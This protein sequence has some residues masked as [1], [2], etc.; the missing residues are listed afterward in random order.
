[1]E[2]QTFGGSKKKAPGPTRTRS[3]WSEGSLPGRLEPGLT[4]LRGRYRGDL[5]PVSLGNPENLVLRSGGFVSR[6]CGVDTSATLR[7]WSH[8]R[9]DRYPGD[10]ENLVSRSGGSLPS[11]RTSA[12]LRDLRA[13][14]RVNQKKPDFIG[15]T[16]PSTSW[17]SVQSPPRQHKTGWRPP[18]QS[19]AT[20]PHRVLQPALT[21]SCN[22]PSQSP[23]TRP[24]RVLQPALTESCNPPSQSP[25]TRPHRVLQPALTESCNPPSQSPAT[26]P[27]RVLQPALTESC[28]PPSQSPTTRPHR[29]LHPF[30]TES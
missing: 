1:M 6:S 12:P 16:K 9:D 7:T 23:T 30:L 26:R 18:S 27:H 11:T 29:V 3:H 10:L 4:G 19:P 13:L 25:A 15:G 14:R 8:G 21:E 17:T 5:N 2:E 28:N 24:H 22:P 20:R